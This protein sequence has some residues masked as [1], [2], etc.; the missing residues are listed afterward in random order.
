MSLQSLESLCQCESTDEVNQALINHSQ[1][2]WRPGMWIEAGEDG[3]KAV[4]VMCTS[5]GLQT[6]G[7]KGEHLFLYDISRKRWLAVSTRPTY[8]V[9]KARLLLT[10]ATQGLLIDRILH[11]SVVEEMNLREEEN[12][13]SYVTLWFKDSYERGPLNLSAQ[14]RGTLLCCA[15]LEVLNVELI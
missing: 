6:Y 7:F 13:A 11:S 9:S 15:L 10:P 1:W 14:E 2:L 4:I 12:D 8:E 5:E 3:T